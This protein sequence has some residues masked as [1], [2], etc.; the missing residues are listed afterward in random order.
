MKRLRNV[1]SGDVDL[2][3][4]NSSY[5]MILLNTHL[6]EWA[7]QHKLTTGKT[8]LFFVVQIESDNMADAFLT[9]VYDDGIAER[10]VHAAYVGQKMSDKETKFCEKLN[11]YTG[12]DLVN[13]PPH[14]VIINK[15]ANL[16]DKSDF[17]NSVAYCYQSLMVDTC[18]LGNGLDASLAT[19]NGSAILFLRDHEDYVTK[20]EFYAKDVVDFITGIEQ[21]Q[22]AK[23]HQTIKTLIQQGS[24]QNVNRTRN[25]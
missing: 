22:A 13:K 2:G 9:L 12:R 14:K 5:L 8:N 10:T 18:A 1:K 6:A 11:H 16:N 24:K 3:V 25:L 20:F 23:V 7:K 21:E 15:L 19:A 4:F 17:V